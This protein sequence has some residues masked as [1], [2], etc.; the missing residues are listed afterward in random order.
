MTRDEIDAGGGA[1]LGVVVVTTLGR[2]IRGKPGRLGS[3]DAKAVND[4][5]RSTPVNDFYAPNG[6]IRA[7]GLLVRDLY[8]LQVKQ[9]GENTRQGDVFNVV[10]TV[11]ADQAFAPLQK[12]RCPLTK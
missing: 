9:P 3:D 2:P 8:I 6:V 5:M 7:D 4:K 1:G 10:A 11:P 12:G